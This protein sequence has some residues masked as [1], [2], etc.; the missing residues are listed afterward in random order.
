VQPHPPAFAGGVVVLDPH[1]DDGADARESVGHN[2]DQQAIPQPTR[3]DVSMLSAG[4]AFPSRSARR[5]AAAHDLLGS[6]H[7]LR[8][9]DGEELADDEPGAGQVQLH[10]GLTAAACS[11]FM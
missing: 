1:A 4:G 5:L 8:R 9:I 6:A 11:A 7:R 2:A 10:V 3:V